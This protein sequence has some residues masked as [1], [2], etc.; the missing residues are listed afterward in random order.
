VSQVLAG[1]GFVERRAGEVVT[2]PEAALVGVLV[3]TAVVPAACALL[4]L[5]LLFH[6]VESARNRAT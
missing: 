1:T 3:A 6:H 5:P 4:S 2:Q